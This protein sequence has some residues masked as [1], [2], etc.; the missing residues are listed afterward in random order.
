MSLLAMVVVIRSWKGMC[1]YG[2]AAVQVYN[3][4]ILR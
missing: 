2:R 1:G 3:Q 4:G